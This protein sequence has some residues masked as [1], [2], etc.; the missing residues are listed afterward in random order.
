[1]LNTRQNENTEWNDVAINSTI[2]PCSL[3]A[4]F[5]LS[6]M[7]QASWPDRYGVCCIIKGS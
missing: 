4:M 7:Y 6:V 2:K 3:P 1:M 5:D